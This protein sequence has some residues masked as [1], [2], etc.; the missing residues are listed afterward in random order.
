[1]RVPGRG[2]GVISVAGARP[3]VPA[4][5][6]P[7]DL[8][9]QAQMVLQGKSRNLIIRELQVRP[10][11]A[12]GPTKD[13]RFCFIFSW[14]WRCYKVSF[15]I[16]DLSSFILSFVLYITGIILKSTRICNV[17]FHVPTPYCAIGVTDIVSECVPP[18][19]DWK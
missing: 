3:V 12:I 10:L 17:G 9:A 5:Y 11:P 8:V 18:E 13:W 2:T 6:V 14:R 1:M 16:T 7:E 19:L 15:A 4:S